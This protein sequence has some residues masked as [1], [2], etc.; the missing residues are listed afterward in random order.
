MDQFLLSSPFNLASNDQSVIGAAL[1][2]TGVIVKNSMEQMQ[3]GNSMLGMGLFVAG[4]VLFANAVARNGATDKILTL[5]YL[6]AGLI[7]G[8]VIGMKTIKS[9]P[10]KQKRMLPYIGG[11]VIGWLL[12][13]YSIGCCMEIV[14]P[15]IALV[16]LSMMYFLPK[17][18][19][20]NVV[21][22]PGL[23]LFML[24]WL[25]LIA[26]NNFGNLGGIK[27]FGG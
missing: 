12:L 25:G 3:A 4:W 26:A 1:I 18:R 5:P 21:D 23:P 2:I 20:N 22:G 17:Q 9:G 11:F 24:A 8:S 10:D 16:F 19:K 13:G 7:V 14:I 27:L 15:S 6:A